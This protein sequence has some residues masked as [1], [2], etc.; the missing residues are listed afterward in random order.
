MLKAGTKVRHKLQSSL[1]GEGTVV[2]DSKFGSVK[3]C[4]ERQRNRVIEMGAV[5][6]VNGNG[7][8][9]EGTTFTN[10]WQSEQVQNLMW[11]N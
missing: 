4:W 9:R 2:Q 11:R 10:W 3:V 5:F 7:K 1:L 6:C 8:T